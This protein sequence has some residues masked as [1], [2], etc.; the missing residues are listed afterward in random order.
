[1]NPHALAELARLLPQKIDFLLCSASYEERCLSIPLL[2]EPARVRVA[3]IAENANRRELHGA[4]PARLNAHFAGRAIE[5][6]LST[7]NPVVTADSLLRALASVQRDTEGR[8]LDIVV[9]IT[10]FTHEALLIVFNLLIECVPESQVYCAYATAREYSIGDRPESKWLSKGIAEVRSV[11]GYPGELRPSRQLH[12][13]VLVGVEHE[14][15]TE[16][17]RVYE[18]SR[19]SLGYAEKSS[20]N[21]EHWK[22]NQHGI[23]AVR[24]VYGEAGVFEFPVFDPDG[25]RRAIVQQMESAGDLNTIVAPMNTKLSTLGAAL[26]CIENTSV[27]L[28]YAQ[29]LIYNIAGYSSPGDEGYLFKVDSEKLRSTGV[30]EA[31]IT[32]M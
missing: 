5:V 19:I 21:Q 16:L 25:T 31:S 2:L 27:Q 4:N 12:L 26:V 23:D 24:A 14:R 3:M 30:N 10:A 8:P 9:D 6:S 29:A 22:A 15:V 13:I 17:I 28:A 18:P 20:S 1:M 11:L 7:R 32:G